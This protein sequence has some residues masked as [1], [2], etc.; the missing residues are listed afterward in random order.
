MKKIVAL[1]MAMMM[2]TVCFTA[3]GE[4]GTSNGGAANSVVYNLIYEP[5][6]LNTATTAD[7]ASFTVMHYMVEGLLR[8]DEN[9]NPI[10][11]IAESW[12]YDEENITYTFHLRTD[13]YWE[14]G[15]PVTAHDFVFAWRQLCKPGSTSNSANQGYIIKNAVAYNN[16]EVGEEEF[17]VHAIDDYTLE[18][19]LENPCGYALFQF[20]STYFAPINQAFYES[21]GDNYATD[22]E[23]LMANGPF[24]M[25]EWVHEDRIIMV[26]NPDYYEAGRIAVE[27]ITF[28]MIGDT[29]AALNSFLAGEIDVLPQLSAEQVTQLQENGREVGHYNNNAARFIIFNMQNEYFANENIRRAFSTAIDRATLT[30]VVLGDGSEAA[31]SYCPGVFRGVS[32]S[33]IEEAGAPFFTDNPGEAAAYLEAGLAEIGKTREDMQAAGLSIVLDENS[34][35]QKVVA[36]LL[37]QWKTELGI[38][39]VASV[40][41]KKSR[42]EKVYTNHDFDLAYGTWGPDYNDPNTNLETFVSTGALNGG[43]FASARYDECIAAAASEAN[44]EQRMEYLIECEQ[45]LMNEVVVAPMYFECAN[46]IVSDRVHNYNPVNWSFA[47]EFI[48]FE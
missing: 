36:Y 6:D 33:F 28:V 43:Q 26:A 9:A 37:E 19:Q 22:K 48:T 46:Y 13:A 7:G 34:I 32:G 17:G 4:G 11:G 16:D 8:R 38:E 10:P 15:E 29:N 45:I 44:L 1:M 2:A 31:Y 23:Y 24:V 41:P 12:E 18:V 35:Y 30:N 5:Q 14:N 47:L 27:E 3:C 25:S 40:M 42:I 20:T 21:C 39:I